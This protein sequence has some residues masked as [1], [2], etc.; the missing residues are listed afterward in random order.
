MS[1]MTMPEQYSTV[2]GAAA[3]FAVRA[4]DGQVRTGTKFPYVVHPLGV[5]HILREYYPDD[6]YLE[7]AGYLHDV[8]EDTEVTIEEV[9]RRFGIIVSYYV[10]AV[11]RKPGWSLEKHLRDPNVARLKAADLIDN[12]LDTIR[13]IEKGHDVWS[14]FSN[15]AAKVN[16]WRKT[17]DLILPQLNNEPI[18]VPLLDAFHKVQELANERV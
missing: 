10:D 15:G 11:T 7:A 3:A 8:V 1:G 18:I 2:A 5:G 6:P 12:M 14:R 13:G 4:H 9:T 16:Y 17:I